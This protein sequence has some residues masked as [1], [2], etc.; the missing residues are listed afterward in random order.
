MNTLFIRGVRVRTCHPILFAATFLMAA[1]VSAANPAIQVIPENPTTSDNIQVRVVGEWNNSCAPTGMQ[2]TRSDD[3]IRTRLTPDASSGDFCLQ[4]ITPYDVSAPVGRLPAGCYEVKPFRFVNDFP[5]ALGTESFCVALAGVGKPDFAIKDIKLEPATPSFGGYVF[6]RV[7]VENRGNA[8]G[9]AG[10]LAVTAD[11]CHYFDGVCL[12]GPMPAREVGLIAPGD[13]TRID[14]QLGVPRAGRLR[15]WAKADASNK[16]D[17]SNEN[18]NVKTL[19]YTARAGDASRPD[20]TIT[21]ITLDPSKPDFGGTFSA[22]VTVK[23]SGPVGG[24]AEWLDVWLNGDRPVGCRANGDASKRVGFLDAGEST[25]LSFRG[26]PS[27]AVFGLSYTFRA[28]V[29][30]ECATQDTNRANNQKTLAYTFQGDPDTFFP[31]SLHKVT[32]FAGNGGSVSPSTP[33][34]IK[35]GESATFTVVPD[36]GYSVNRDV[37][38]TCPEGRWRGNTLTSSMITETCTVRFRF[39]P[40]FCLECVIPGG[41]R[42]I[43]R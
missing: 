8:V 4:V 19:D 38:G 1:S 33:Q 20:F 2:N 24:D 22:N 15:F 32:P 13:H 26:L 43:L 16:T 10:V 21:A 42:A 41:W 25:T 36:A 31:L 12:G 6:A 23:N 40:D 35:N 27:Q 18:N 28:H 29:D 7:Y 34:F 39:V 9:E 30:N 17:E 3:L 11:D 14:F 5:L 37:G